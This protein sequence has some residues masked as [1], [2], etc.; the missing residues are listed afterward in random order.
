MLSP[1]QPKR[2]WIKFENWGI[3]FRISNRRVVDPFFSRSRGLDQATTPKLQYK[4]MFGEE[5]SGKRKRLPQESDNLK[6][7]K[8]PSFLRSR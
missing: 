8:I 1:E 5:D 3:T 6:P 4:P 7:L 2:R